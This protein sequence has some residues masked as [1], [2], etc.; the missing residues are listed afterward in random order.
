MATEVLHNVHFHFWAYN[1]DHKN[2]LRVQRNAVSWLKLALWKCNVD[3]QKSIYQ[4]IITERNLRWNLLILDPFWFCCICHSTYK[5]TLLNF[6]LVVQ[7]YRTCLQFHQNGLILISL[8]LFQMTC[9][10][11]K[12]AFFTSHVF[13]KCSCIRHLVTTCSMTLIF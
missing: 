6:H 2:P 4:S 13:L 11:M 5:S 3:Y 7:W 9:T 1:L 10:N 12:F 8:C